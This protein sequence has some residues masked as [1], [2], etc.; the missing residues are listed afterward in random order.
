MHKEILIETARGET[1]IAVIENGKLVELYF[2]EQE[3]KRYAGDIYKGRVEDVLPG[4]GSAFVDIG[5]EKRGFLH[6]S[7]VVLTNFEDV[8][9]YFS[10]RAGITPPAARPGAINSL[11][12]GQDI[13][14]QV[15]KEAIG[16]KGPKLTTALTIP[17]RYVVLMPYLS[18]VNVSSRIEDEAERERLKRVVEQARPPGHGFIVRTAAQGADEERVRADMQELLQIWEN[19]TARAEKKHAPALLYKDKDLLERVIR[20]EFTA[21]VNVL[22]TDDLG[23][24]DRVVKLAERYSPSLANRVRLYED[25]QDLF[26]TFGVEAE[27]D[28]MFR[29]KVWLRSGGYI[30]IDEAEALV[31]IDVNT[32]RFLGRGDQEETALQTNLEAAAEIARQVR[33]RDIGGL[34][35]IDFIDMNEEEHRRQVLAALKE[36]MARDRAK[37]KILELS[38]LGMVEMTRQRHRPSWI[39]AVTRPCPYC[40]GRGT[41]LDMEVIGGKVERELNRRFRL[42]GEKE[43]T[44]VVHNRVKSYLEETFGDRFNRLEIEHGARIY[45]C[46]RDDVAL[47]DIEFVDHYRPVKTTMQ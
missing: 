27:I 18:R 31:A 39:A 19:I 2:E 17:G 23:V 6:A 9:E 7:D 35:I 41:V 45:L 32:G 10:E 25:E 26:D 20:D 43:V 34:I 37:S 47:D 24:Y 1:R 42:C 3:Q 16:D 8:D 13:I 4:L 38:E 29:R 14:V 40:R 36:H 15:V 5:F 46:G 21:D 33:L 22:I 11:R 30:V 28:R 12:P 44:V